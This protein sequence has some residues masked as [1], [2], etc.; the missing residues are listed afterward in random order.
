MVTHEQA[1]QINA[2]AQNLS[3]RIC[4]DIFAEQDTISGKDLLS[5]TPVEQINYF[6]LKV[7]YRSWQ[8][9][10]LHMESPY[11]NYKQPEVRQALHSFMNTLSQHIEIK[12]PALQ[13]LLRQACSD[14]LY[15]ILSP[16]EFFR[17]ELVTSV[18]TLSATYLRNTKKYIRINADVLEAFTAYFEAEEL[19]EITPTRSAELLEACAKKLRQS[20]DPT[21]HLAAL[22]DMFPLSE[23]MYAA[24]SIPKPDASTM[25]SDTE[26]TKSL[27]TSTATPSTPSDDEDSSLLSADIDA[28]SPFQAPVSPLDLDTSETEP[29]AQPFRSSPSPSFSAEALSSKKS[30]KFEITKEEAED[31]TRAL[32]SNKIELYRQALQEIFSCN[33]FDEAIE[34]LLHRYGRP[35]SWNLGSRE[36][37]TLFRAIYIYF[38]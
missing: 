14:T 32:F 8:K 11:F 9:E 5:L 20:E 4:K 31:V 2:Y 17:T 28:E 36:A 34:I 6:V 21:P 18:S 16:D 35:K 27:D 29:S 37:K 30:K 10:L 23:A 12:E 7:L 33:T 22:A 25:P 38:R 24:S 19:E 26:P 3:L 15:L 1:D 13:P